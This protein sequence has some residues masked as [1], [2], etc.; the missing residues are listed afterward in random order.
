MPYIPQDD[1]LMGLTDQNNGELKIQRNPEVMEPVLRVLTIKEQ[2]ILEEA[3][4]KRFAMPKLKLTLSQEATS[5]MT[6][7]RLKVSNPSRSPASHT[8]KEEDASREGLGYVSHIRHEDPRN[9]FEG[10]YDQLHGGQQARQSGAE[11][12][13]E[14][15]SFRIGG[16]VRFGGVT[17]PQQK[18]AYRLENEESY[19]RSYDQPQEGHQSGAG[20]PTEPSSFRI[21]GPVR[22]YEI[23]NPRFLEV[24]DQPL[25]SSGNEH[26]YER[27]NYDIRQ[28]TGGTI[29]EVVDG[30]F[31]GARRKEFQGVGPL[32]YRNKV[33]NFNRQQ[34]QTLEQKATIE[35]VK[36][37]INPKTMDHVY[38]TP[39]FPTQQERQVRQ[40]EDIQ[41]D[42]FLQQKDAQRNAGE[43]FKAVGNPFRPLSVS[44]P[45]KVQAEAV[46]ED[47]ENDQRN[48]WKR[49]MLRNLKQSSLSGGFTQLQSEN[50]MLQLQEERR[51]N[52]QKQMASI[53]TLNQSIN[54][55]VE[56]NQGS[57]EDD[58]ELDNFENIVAS[59]DPALLSAD[60]ATRLEVMETCQINLDKVLQRKSRR[61][62]HLKAEQINIQ[63]LNRRERGNL[64]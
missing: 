39:T 61:L 57:I 64:E 4:Q 15:P 20:Q 11:Q 26:N 19:L 17:Q 35:A 18:P 56:S 41:R 51:V 53:K 58:L 30:A 38:E 46:S 47:L 5:A 6:N 3:E 12:P 25:F 27:G 9:S 52:I 34:A 36:L 63:N 33:T 22:N 60:Y 10:S 14:Q 44:T 31:G 29:G 37:T 28:P 59:T 1:D 7:A 45:G 49:E 50:Y 24:I 54:L 55:E 16:Q 48:L 2:E 23:L 40:Q 21:G 13:M 8:V 32:Q 62:Q 43:T 42:R